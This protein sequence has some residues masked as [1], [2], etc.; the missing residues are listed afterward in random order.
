MRVGKGEKSLAV[1]S[2][3][4]KEDSFALILSLERTGKEVALS[5]LSR[6]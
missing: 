4:R 5:S 3:M 1:L 6:V 2:S